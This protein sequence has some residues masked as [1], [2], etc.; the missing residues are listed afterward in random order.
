[1]LLSGCGC[2]VSGLIFAR[3][4]G[5]ESESDFG[6]GFGRRRAG[7]ARVGVSGNSTASSVSAGFAFDGCRTIWAVVASLAVSLAAR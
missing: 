7:I 2:C 3:L 4:E 1:M 5:S 6:A